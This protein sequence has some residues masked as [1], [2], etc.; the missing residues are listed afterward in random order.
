[1]SCT[2]Y[3]ADAEHVQFFYVKQLEPSTVSDW[4]ED[5]LKVLMRLNGLSDELERTICYTGELYAY[6]NGENILLDDGHF[7]IL[8]WSYMDNPYYQEDEE[9]GRYRLLVYEKHHPVETVKLSDV[10]DINF[11]YSA[12]E[13]LSN[14]TT[15]LC[16]DGKTI[17]LNLGDRRISDALITGNDDTS[18]IYS[19]LGQYEDKFFI[20]D[21]VAEISLEDDSLGEVRVIDDGVNELVTAIGN[22]IYYV[23]NVY[24][25]EGN[26]ECELYY[27]GHYLLSSVLPFG[28]PAGNSFFFLADASE[29]GGILVKITGEEVTEL[30]ENVNVF[31]PF[32]ENSVAIMSE[33]DAD[34]LNGD[35]WYY[36]G[37]DIRLVDT[38]VHLYLNTD[39]E[40]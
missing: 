30:A 40:R 31:Y 37:E 39:A 10:D 35:L 12:I 33:Y 36:N 34:K 24:D 28:F 20:F 25:S 19:L 14:K 7:S 15:Y 38:D 2:I 13:K 4:I 32:A 9:N 17:K 16:V 3:G 1:M 23:K 18:K 22:S 11:V 5:D 26:Q 29:H 6:R 27:N 21:E 8:N